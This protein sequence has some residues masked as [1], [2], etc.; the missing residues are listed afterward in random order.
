[1]V[2]AQL[3]ERSLPIPEVRGL[4]PVI[5]KNLFILNICLLSTVFW[6]DEIKKKRLGMAHFLKELINIREKQVIINFYYNWCRHRKRKVEI[7]RIARSGGD[8]RIL[9]FRRLGVGIPVLVTGWFIFHIYILWKIGVGKEVNIRNNYTER[10]SEREGILKRNLQAP[11]S[12]GY[13]R[14]LMF[15]RSWVRIPLPYTGWTFFTFICCK[16]CNLCLKRRK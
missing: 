9:M 5:G 13:G 7:E 6:K 12:S 16:N 1:M 14:R 2:V 11:W 8:G 15:Q 3:V 4:N 10:S